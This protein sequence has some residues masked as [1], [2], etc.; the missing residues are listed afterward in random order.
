MDI[1]SVGDIITASGLLHNFIIDE[2]DPENANFAAHFDCEIIN[3]ETEHSHHG[4]IPV[5]MHVV[6]QQP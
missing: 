3:G 4:E 6:N 5:A 1:G 2:R